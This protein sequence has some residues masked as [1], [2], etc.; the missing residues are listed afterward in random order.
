VR[1]LRRGRQPLTSV[2]HHGAVRLALVVCVVALLAAPAALARETA[3]GVG[4]REYRVSL[5]RD[6]VRAGTIKLNL[7]NYGEDPHDL[8]VRTPGGRVVARSAPV[9]PFGGRLTFRVRLRT[10]GRYVVFCTIADHERLGMH[11]R[12]TVSRR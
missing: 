9:D 12:L 6:H 3:V 4:L 7:T 8:A 1:A 5:Y 10:P 2:C 11:A